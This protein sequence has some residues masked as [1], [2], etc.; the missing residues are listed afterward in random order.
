M[1]KQGLQEPSFHVNI[2]D[3]RADGYRFLVNQVEKMQTMKRIGILVAAASLSF[4]LAASADD[5][6]DIQASIIRYKEAVSVNRNNPTTRIKLGNFYLMSNNVE[7]AIDQFKRAAKLDP[8]SAEPHMGLAKAYLKT[9]ALDPAIVEYKE[10]VRLEPSNADY[11]YKLGSAYFSKG[12]DDDA[13]A[14][15]RQGIK[16]NNSHASCHRQLGA[17]LGLK[18][19]FEAQIA[20]EKKAI[21]LAPNDD[22]AYFCLGSAYFYLAKPEFLGE[23]KKNFEK[24]IQL[25]PQYAQAHHLLAITLGA[26]KNFDQAIKSEET[27]IELEPANADYKQTLKKLRAQQITKR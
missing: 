18:G 12:R 26:M 22:Y 17:L 2:P 27:A 7:D 14:S 23:A 3:S 24:S 8:A 11:H 10:A 15:F 19:D 20:E 1:S 9:R 25:N 21:E 6:E 16:A 4:N 13:I 5:K